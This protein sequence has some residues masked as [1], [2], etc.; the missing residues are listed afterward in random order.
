MEGYVWAGPVFAFAMVL[1]VSS[2]GLS[3]FMLYD[4]VRRDAARYRVPEP[5]WLYPIV[6]G[7]YLL[8]VVLAFLPAMK[9]RVGA[10][11]AIATPL[12]LVVGVAYLLRVVFPKPPAPAQPEEPAPA[13]PE[14]PVEPP[15]S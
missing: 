8:G 4:T 10:A 6:S 11:I 14:E 7:A 9:G 2:A 15:V 13:Q 1:V 5:R 12:V 3:A